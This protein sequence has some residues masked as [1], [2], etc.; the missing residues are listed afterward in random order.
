M[1]RL[2]KN[3]MSSKLII[4]K[5]DGNFVQSKVIFL[6]STDENKTQEPGPFGEGIFPEIGACQEI[7]NI[8]YVKPTVRNSGKLLINIMSGENELILNI[9]KCVYTIEDHETKIAN[10]RGNNLIKSVKR[11]SW[12]LVRH[13]FST[14]KLGIDKICEKLTE[15]AYEKKFDMQKP[16]E[17]SDTTATINDEYSW[18]YRIKTI[19]N[20]NKKIEI[21][22]TVLDLIH[23]GGYRK[24]FQV[25]Q[26]KCDHCKMNLTS[27][28]RLRKHMK[29]HIEFGNRTS[30]GENRKNKSFKL[31][32]N[33]CTVCRS[34]VMMVTK[35]VH[36]SRYIF[37][38]N[39]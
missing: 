39:D 14:G 19:K 15:K 26:F 23:S 24:L 33:C 6:K 7:W 25:K 3:K 11:R 17:N 21:N 29:N 28:K 20:M 31:S 34:N 36:C 12:K 2:T 9:D 38:A 16:W 18:D 32:P 10:G 27:A 4:N 37:I 5:I 1:S 30:A 8:G 13:F 35:S 22:K